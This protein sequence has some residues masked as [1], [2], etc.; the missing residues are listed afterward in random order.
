MF[1]LKVVRGFYYRVA[2]SFEC[3]ADFIK[4]SCI[5]AIDLFVYVFL[6]GLYVVWSSTTYAWRQHI[7]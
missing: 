1:G 2:V 5:V 3:N 6:I 4:Y 7:H